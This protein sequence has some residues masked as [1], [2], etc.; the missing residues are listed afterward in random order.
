MT[1][2]GKGKVEHT[3]E[4]PQ[5]VGRGGG[6]KRDDAKESEWPCERLRSKLEAAMRSDVRALVSR[7]K[8]WYGAGSGGGDVGVGVLKEEE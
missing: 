6:W 7:G 5:L 1:S 2:E 3:L 4:D 8:T